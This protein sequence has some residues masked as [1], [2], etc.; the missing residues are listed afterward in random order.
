MPAAI[1]HVYVL[2]LVLISFVIFNADGLGGAAADLK[3]LF[4]GAGLPFVTQETLYEVRSRAVLLVMAAVGAT[5][6]PKRI[7]A[8][9]SSRF[10]RVRCVAEPLCM[11]LLLLLATAYLVD[12]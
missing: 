2:L 3:A 7:A 5:P 11:L 4:G 1:G 12:G 10:G 6:L 9:L 8:C